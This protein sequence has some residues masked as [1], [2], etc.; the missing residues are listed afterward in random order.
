VKRWRPPKRTI[1]KV[2]PNGIERLVA[3]AGVGGEA[4]VAETKAEAGA[5]AGAR[6]PGPGSAMGVAASVGAATASIEAPA[7]SGGATAVDRAKRRGSGSVVGY[8]GRFSPE[9]RVD[10]LVRA[11]AVLATDHP[12]STLALA[13]SGDGES[14]LRTLATELGV[15][16]RVRF[17]GWVDSAQWLGGID[18]LCLPSVWENCS[19]ALLE[20]LAAGIGV[21]AAP[22]GGNPELLPDSALADP[23]NPAAFAAAIAAQLTD[24]AARPTLASTIPTVAGMAGQVALVYRRVT[25][26]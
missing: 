14:E 3:R 24:P 1:V 11:F 2:I 13:G 12:E 25:A 15:A 22:V 9:K 16:N 26:G 10:L 7:V 19:Y 8:L 17:D 21:V 23:D 18:V 4:A 5:V 20:A 6:Q